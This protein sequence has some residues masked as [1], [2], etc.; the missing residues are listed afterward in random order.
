MM[1]TLLPKAFENDN[2]KQNGYKMLELWAKPNGY[3]RENW[4]TV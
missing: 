2:I 1:E 4:M 3:F